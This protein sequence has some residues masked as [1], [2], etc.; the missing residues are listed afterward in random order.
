MND[1]RIHRDLGRIDATLKAQADKIAHLSDTQREIAERV[2]NIHSVLMQVGGGWK[3]LL[4][5]G[6]LSSA[7]T[8]VVMKI[9]G[10]VRFGP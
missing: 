5:V 4:M 2:E 7:I 6:A 10:L 8:G 1:P 9:I 3:T